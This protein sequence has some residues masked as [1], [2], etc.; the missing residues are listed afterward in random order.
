[1]A[2]KWKKTSNAE[3]HYTGKFYRPI[4]R[5]LDDAVDEFYEGRIGV[6]IFPTGQGPI[7]RFRAEFKFHYPN[8]VS[9]YV[10]DDALRELQRAVRV[11]RRKIRKLE[12]IQYLPVWAKFVRHVLGM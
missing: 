1:M 10:P 3:R 5:N 2:N 8:N 11:T 9:D 12:R 4:A 6:R 7:Y